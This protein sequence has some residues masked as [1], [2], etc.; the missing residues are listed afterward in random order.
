M[1]Q[2]EIG[3]SVRAKVEI[4][5]IK[6]G[7]VGVVR[8]IPDSED[9]GVEWE[10]LT[11]GH[12]LNGKLPN[13]KKGWYVPLDSVER[14]LTVKASSEIE[15]AD[16]TKVVLPKGS[17][18][19]DVISTLKW[20]LKQQEAG[21]KEVAISREFH[22][23]PLDGAFALHQALSEMFGWVDLVPTPGFFGPTP[24]VMVEIDAGAGRTVVVP[25]GRVQVPVW[26]GGYVEAALKINPSRFWLRGGIQKQFMEDIQELTKRI[27]WFLDHASLYR[28]KAIHV[29][30]AWKREE[31][32][33]DPVEH[34]PKFLQLTAAEHDLIFDLRT[35]RLLRVGLFTP[36][37]HIQLCRKLGVPIRRGILLAGSF[38]TGKTL[39]AL[40]TATKALAAGWAFIYASDARDFCEAVELGRQY[41][42]AVVFVEDID[43]ITAGER[44]QT[45]DRVLNVIDGLDSKHAEVLVVVTTNDIEAIHPAMLRPGRIDTVIELGM[46][47]AES[48]SQLLERYGQGQLK[49]VDVSPVIG[50]LVGK[51]P[52]MIREIVE[53]SRLV[54]VLRIAEGGPGVVTVD[55]LLTSAEMVERHTALVNRPVTPK[56]RRYPTEFL[57]RVPEHPPELI[58]E[59]SELI[60]NR[61]QK[62]G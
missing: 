47:D 25:W 5:H 17:R 35:W 10:R 55:D 51:S 32:N 45:M 27:Q 59:I 33:F 24:P 26:K 49:D 20:A 46:P 34:S 38:G 44:D 8:D 31:L 23:F 14:I 57:V 9:L 50:Q 48:V 18:I 54:A 36:I 40:V 15:Y 7:W 60:H 53:R 39:T 12:N 13:S 1:D 16:T 30:F 11:S 6:T 62:G 43:R 28:N 42:P 29:S 4:N 52:A 21:E 56:S 22:C 3:M 41:T 2:F 37:S 58:G 61:T 19:I